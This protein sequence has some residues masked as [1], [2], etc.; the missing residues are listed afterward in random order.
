MCFPKNK[1]KRLK[2][3][4]IL[5]KKK[6]IIAIAAILLAIVISFVG[7]QTFAKYITEV[8]GTGTAEVA[9]WS[10][11]VNGKDSG[12]Q[13][14]SLAST[15]NNETLV[16]NKIAPGTSGGF[17]IKI[18]GAGSD[19]GIQ[20]DIDFANETTKPTNLVYHYNGKTYTT[21]SQIKDDANGVINAN[22]QEKQRNIHID[23]E[24]PYETGTEANV[25]ASNDAVDTANAKAIQNYSFDVVVTGT[26]V[27]P[28]E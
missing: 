5:S 23:W 9:N 18:D 22:D 15:I 25:V 27:V 16:N 17:D 1:I 19:V 2:E 12:V 4:F 20:Y 14:I 10:F 3:E 11:K 28:N 13:T 7:G 26:Q 21:I 6:K 8:K 24:W